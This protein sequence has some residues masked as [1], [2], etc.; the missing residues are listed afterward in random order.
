[1]IKNK[2]DVF[3]SYRRAGGLALARCICYYLRSRGVKCFF[4]LKEIRDGKF[5]EKI[6]AAIEGSKYFLLLITK[7]SLVRCA[8]EKDWFRKEI[9]HAM[10]TKDRRHDIVPVMV[11]G[12]EVEFPED[13]P[14]GLHELRTI[15]RETIDIEEHFERDIDDTLV[16]RMRRVGK[17]VSRE[18]QKQIM[19]RREET[20]KAFRERAWRFKTEDKIRID[21]G[22]GHDKLLR[23][24]EELGISSARAEI[25][26]EEVNRAVSWRRRLDAWIKTHPLLTIGLV[27]SILLALAVSVYHVIPPGWRDCVDDQFLVPTKEFCSGIW[28]TVFHRR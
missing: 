19:R 16:N 7:E 27:L 26:I 17:R 13:F 2:Y 1:M 24:A 21:I 12:Q 15:Q 25:L 23:L 9:E 14:E 4:D 8:D 10:T 5:D 3:I 6:Y 28:D 18:A 11:K 20:E 22:G